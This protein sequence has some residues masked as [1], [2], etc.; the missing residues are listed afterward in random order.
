MGNVAN[1]FSLPFKSPDWFPRLLITGLIA[2]VPVIGWINLV[3][4]MLA[5]LDN[6]RRGVVELPPAG[7]N[8]IGRGATLFLVA[9]VYGL[10]IGVILVLPVVLLTLGSLNSAG[11]PPA[12]PTGG[13]NPT[14]TG[15]GQV[16]PLAE[17]TF[18]PAVVICTERNGLAGGFNVREVFRL[19]SSNWKNSLIAGVLIYAAGYA[20]ALGLLAC[21]VGILVSYP[22]FVATTAGIIRYY[23]ATFEPPQQVPQPY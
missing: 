11:N 2:L 9:L 10:A 14:L 21:C 4:W 13:F 20:G 3:G 22:Y 16:V 18:L 17:Y 23:E 19:A 6:Y 5:T 8:Y 1:A 12:Y 7:F 15:L